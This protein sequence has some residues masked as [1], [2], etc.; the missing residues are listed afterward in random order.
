MPLLDQTGLIADRFERPTPDG[1]FPV[2]PV[3]VDWADLPDAL[4]RASAGQPIGVHIANTLKA[5]ELAFLLPRLALISIA[6]PAFG[7]GRGFSIAHQLRR[8]GFRGRLRATGP[9]I[10]DQFAF[11]LQCG[12]DEVDVPEALHA[13][14]PVHEWLHALKTI[15]VPYQTSHVGVAGTS[16]LERRRAARAAGAVHVG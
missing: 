16:V 12:F 8:K 1:A 3:L 7:D 4:G 15:S 2:G 11:A 10:A 13:R 14:Q 9:L 5:T 6:F